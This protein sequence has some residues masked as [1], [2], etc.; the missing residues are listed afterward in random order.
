MSGVEDAETSRKSH[1]DPYTPHHTVPTVQK[2][3]EEKQEREDKYGSAEGN[4]DERSKLDR[5]KDGY[6]TIRHGR[7]AVNPNE[8]TQ[9]YKSENKNLAHED[10]IA[11][12]FTGQVG[13]SEGD[14][15]RDNNQEDGGGGQDTTE[16]MLNETDPKKARKAMKKFNADGTERQVTDPV[17]H[18]PVKI[19]DFTT[20]EMKRTPHNGPPAGSEHQSA[21]GGAAMNKSE[22][23]LNEEAQD[24]QDAHTVMEALFPPPD[25]EVTREELTD[26]YKKAMTAGLGIVSVSLTAVVAL[27]QFTRSSTGWSRAFFTLVEIGV[28]L[29]VSAA[30]ILG[31]RQWTE[32]KIRGVWDTEVWHAERQQGKKLAKSQTAESAQWLNSLL[33]S[34]W[35]LI[36]PDLFLSVSD[37]LEDVMQASLPKMVRMVSVDDIGQ[38]SEALRILGVRWLPTGAA[39]KSVSQDGQLQSNNEEKNDRSVPGEGEVQ[40]DLDDKNQDDEGE[41]ENI[42]QGMEAE[43]GDFVNVEIAFAYRPSTG[44]KGMKERAKNAHLYMAFYMFANVKLPVW[45]ELHGMVGTMRLR[46]QLTPDPPFFSLCT[47]TFLGQ[48]RVDLACI[49]LIKKG[50]NLMDLPLISSFVQSSVDAAMAEYVAP[51]SLTLDLKDMLM[52][53]D[54]KKDT[55]ARGVLAITIKHASDFKQGDAGFGPFKGGSADPYVSVGWAKFGKPLWSTRVLQ[56]NMEPY[57][58]ETC[59]ILVTPDELNVDEKLRIQI[60]DS[61][62]TTADDDLGRVEMDLKKLMKDSETNGRMSNREDSVKALKAGEGMPG[63][64]QWSVGYFSKTRITDDQLTAQEED[65]DVKDIDQLKEKVYRESEKKL[66]EASKDETDE[67][68]QQKA[69]DLKARQ[70]QLIIASP[71]PQQYPS[72]I[73]SVQIHQITGLEL[74][75][76]NK[77]KASKKQSGADEEEEGEDLPSSYCTIII[78]HQKVFRTRTKPKNSKPFFNAGCERFVPDYRNAEVHIAVR[79]SRVHEDDPLLGIIHLPLEKILKERSQIDGN[80]PLSGGVGYG[81][82]RISMI[83]RSVQLQA[84]PKMLGWEYGTVEINPVVKAI[85]LPKELE[86]LRMKIRTNLA[87]GKLHSGT[88]DG[89][90]NQHDGHV[91]WK[92]KKDGP[93]RLPVRKRYSTP[94]IVELRKDA[95]LADHTPAFCVLWLR[96]IPDNEEQTLRLPVWKGDL[97]R[98]EHNTLAS[99]GDKVGEIELSLTF[100]SGLSGYHAGFA[101]KDS[102]LSDVLEV[103]DTCHDNDESEW[104]NG[105]DNSSSSSSSSSEDSDDDDANGHGRSSSLLPSSLSRRSKTNSS[106]DADGKRGMVDNL[107]EY[108]THAK[109]LHRRNRGLMQWRGPRTVA[110]MKHVAEKGERKVEGLFRHSERGGA[111]VETEV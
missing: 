39:A 93:I 58:N 38:G 4:Q 30:V 45:V 94:L 44:R 59:F 99:C 18:L 9:P 84:P 5:L 63:K 31:V 101:K 17:T 64:L 110:W 3:R 77:N 8:S 100:W 82:A 85:D 69:Q 37:T 27:F 53:D 57:W 68:E 108:K 24:A 62:R 103:L 97:K 83:F 46:L 81:R 71:P 41:G 90:Q 104:D 60:W 20:K 15:D 28:S 88:Q 80:F 13:H 22:H 26:V 33:A 79:D 89:Q 98:A 49:P 40:S 48:P 65:P 7:E 76:V 111:G 105:D 50:P 96:D 73:L 25:F 72:G 11:P 32:N 29:G 6:T 42:D 66:R 102:N 54:F 61:D 56:D 47:L 55:N 19:H 1:R 43:E 74:E 12:E 78:N 107:K 51:K 21:T 91:V 35:P 16:G 10:E 36:N 52:G 87:R 109:Q 106:L 14:G 2:Y 86:N 23:D 67:I 92:P 34:I 95:T 70:D 75:V